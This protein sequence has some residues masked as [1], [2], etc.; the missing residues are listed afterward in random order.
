M[1]TSLVSPFIIYFTQRT[2]Y[3]EFTRSVPSYLLEG[4]RDRSLAVVENTQHKTK[5][6]HG[7]IE[8][9]YFFPFERSLNPRFVQLGPNFKYQDQFLMQFSIGWWL[10]VTLES[11]ISGRRNAVA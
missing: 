3:T 5:R 6:G 10:T 2:L 4:E 8:N 1:Y 7:S 9:Y 11:T